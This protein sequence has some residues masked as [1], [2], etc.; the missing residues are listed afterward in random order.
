MKRSF[1]FSLLPQRWTP[2]LIAFVLSFL[3]AS[4]YSQTLNLKETKEQDM[5]VWAFEHGENPLVGVCLI[6]PRGEA[7]EPPAKEGSYAL[8]QNLLMEGTAKH[9]PEALRNFL[10]DNGL[11]ISL[12]LN[13]GDT[14][15]YM[16]APTERLPQLYEA[17]EDI[18]AR[19]KFSEDRLA[20]LKRLALSALD[21]LGESQEYL[22]ERLFMKVACG[23]H[24]CGKTHV[25]TKESLEGL[26][27]EDM[28]AAHKRL[29]NGEGLRI[30]M[31]GDLNDLRKREILRVIKKTFPQDSQD[32]VTLLPP[33]PGTL[34]GQIHFASFDS[35]QAQV[36]YYK[37]APAPQDPDY[38]PLRMA[39]GMIG[40]NGFNARLF[41]E[42]RVKRAL[43][44]HISES[45]PTGPLPYLPILEG[46]STTKVETVDS[47]VSGIKEVY[48]TT[49]KQGAREAD[50][51]LS[52]ILCKRN[53]ALN[54]RTLMG[55]LGALSE[56]MAKG[57]DVSYVSVYNDRVDRVTLEEMN[58][59]LK[60]YYDP[61]EM[62]ILVSGNKPPKGALIEKISVP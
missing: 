50:L 25:G 3:C 43:T 9:S 23:D 51:H 31:G 39:T 21:K 6:F 56:F 12:S 48:E 7:L 55:T 45:V 28:V 42:V 30:V 53:F 26:N 54:F 5:T 27:R 11:K 19:P 18:F 35:P 8:M 57:M 4:A 16:M 58:A 40:G 22:M 49:R 34:T 37:K 52:K 44:Y 33:A 17:L 62:T 46:L 13:L 14:R 29:F 1:F 38:F 59:A 20:H 61:K 41:E 15:V 32:P 36:K 60:T 47:L 10:E 2:S 24:A